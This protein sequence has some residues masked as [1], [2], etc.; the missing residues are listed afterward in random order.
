MGGSSSDSPELFGDIRRNTRK[1]WRD[2]L[3]CCHVKSSE[4][5]D[6][7]AILAQEKHFATEHH[8]LPAKVFLSVGGKEIR[9]Y[10]A[11]RK[12]LT[13]DMVGDAKGFESLLA[14]RH[15]EGLTTQFK[16]VPD[17]DHVT[18]VGP[19]IRWGLHLA[20]QSGG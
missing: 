7:H 2:D 11:A 8:R 14:S 10:D 1:R 16:V 6:G 20:L 15:Y 18:S 12:G 5:Y 9:Q 13:Q 17:R 19:G 4:G 3:H